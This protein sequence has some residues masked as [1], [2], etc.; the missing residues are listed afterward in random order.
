LMAGD[1]LTVDLQ[2][3]LGAAINRVHGYLHG[4]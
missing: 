3:G 2:S 4:A 1:H